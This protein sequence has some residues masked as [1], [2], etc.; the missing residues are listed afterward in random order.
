[1]ELPLGWW[2]PFLEFYDAKLGWR[3]LL[4][5]AF[6]GEMLLATLIASAVAWFAAVSEWNRRERKRHVSDGE[7]NVNDN[8]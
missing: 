3:G 5:L 8:P 6:I 1:M 4:S 7:R 2:Y